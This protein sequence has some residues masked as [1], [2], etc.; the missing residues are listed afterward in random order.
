M[1]MIMMKLNVISLTFRKENVCIVGL[2]IRS[3]II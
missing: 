1:N 2:N 3:K